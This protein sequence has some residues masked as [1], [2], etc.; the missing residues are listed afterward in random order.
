MGLFDFLKGKS[1]SEK[2][3]KT[4]YD[5]L[6]NTLKEGS[7]NSN[8]G[9]QFYRFAYMHLPRL[10]FENPNNS[11]E[12][13]YSKG[14]EEVVAEF[15]KSCMG[16]GAMP[17][18]S[19]IE[20][21]SV[22]FY[23]SKGIKV[24]II[25]FPKIENATHNGSPIL[26]P[27]KIG[28]AHNAKNLRYFTVGNGLFSDSYTLREISSNMTNSNLGEAS[29]LSDDAFLSDINGKLEPS[30]EIQIK[31][32]LR[33]SLENLTSR[34]GGL[35]LQDF[36]TEI[37]YQASKF[38]I[39]NFK[40]DL[41]TVHDINLI[42]AVLSE[43]KKFQPIVKI[44]V[45]SGAEMLPEQYTD[46]HKKAAYHAIYTNISWG[47]MWDHLRDYFQKKHGIAIDSIKAE[48]LIFYSTRHTRFENNEIVSE[49]DVER[50]IN[51]N[52]F[53]KKEKIIVSIE[54]TLSAKTA[55]VSGKNDKIWT[56]VGEDPDY[57]FI[58]HLDKFEEVDK[59]VLELPNRNLKIIYT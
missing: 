38:L 50:N 21:I 3:P 12:K 49:D 37:I 42:N 7:K 35:T 31:E 54:P 52:F 36:E 25:N 19:D 45:E 56:Y 33:N 30:F 24:I 4:V 2:K 11:L 22:N 23:E 39:K 58:I 32:M 27:I 13:I 40:D 8:S 34:Q 10:L 20:E 6:T 17:K 48:P 28:I 18:T 26:P 44:F 14:K 29:G 55:F 9:L 1:S 57:K 51:I 15:T 43:N 5:E 16:A 59:F 46:E 47:G 53:N 41:K